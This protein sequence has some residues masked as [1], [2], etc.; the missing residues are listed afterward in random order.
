MHGLGSDIC[1]CGNSRTCPHTDCFRHTVNKS[2]DETIFT[3][4]LLKWTD[5]CPY[6][7]SEEERD[8]YGKF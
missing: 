6:F 2:E 7:N 3:M 1:W 4:A 5:A 8:D